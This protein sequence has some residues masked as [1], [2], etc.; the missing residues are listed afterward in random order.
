MVES[1]Q[2]EDDPKLFNAYIE[3]NGQEVTNDE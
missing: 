1:N 2:V 3:I